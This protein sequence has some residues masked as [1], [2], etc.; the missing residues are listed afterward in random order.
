[1]YPKYVHFTKKSQWQISRVAK[2]E[3]KKF[4]PQCL[5]FTGKKITKMERLSKDDANLV[6]VMY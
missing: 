3:P 1:M 5:L 2:T 4:L 6:K